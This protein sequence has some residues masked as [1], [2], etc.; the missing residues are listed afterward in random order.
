MVHT[1][2]R[3]LCNSYPYMC[4]ELFC[5]SVHSSYTVYTE[6][7]CPYP[8]AP[9][10]HPR[11]AVSAP[12]ARKKETWCRLDT[13]LSVGPQLIP[14]RVTAEAKG[15]CGTTDEAFVVLTCACAL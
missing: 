10:A 7:N 9:A 6:A 13:V 3:L 14:S 2:M 8:A 1:H 4:T 15:A 11:R 5:S 12:I